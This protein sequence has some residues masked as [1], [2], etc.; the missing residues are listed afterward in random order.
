MSKIKKHAK[1]KK[2]LINKF[3]RPTLKLE[4]FLI[5]YTPMISVPPKDAPACKV[6]PKPAPHIKP[7]K[8]HEPKV[9]LG[10]RE[11]G[12]MG[13]KDKNRVVK[14]TQISV[15]RQKRRLTPLNAKKKSGTLNR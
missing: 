7:P 13:M 15:C 8:R 3:T 11:C 9:S 5:R 10:K 4:P 12:G 1:Y 2:R 6:S 14:E